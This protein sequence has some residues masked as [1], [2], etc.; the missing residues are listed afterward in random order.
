LGALGTAASRARRS[1]CPATPLGLAVARFVSEQETPRPL[2]TLGEILQ[3]LVDDALVLV[4]GVPLLIR[5]PRAQVLHRSQLYCQPSRSCKSGFRPPIVVMV[6]PDGR[7][8]IELSQ[9]RPPPLLDR[10][11]FS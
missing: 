3:L 7:L 2:L 4:S 9:L 6:N 11:G 1:T 5:V 8:W 10:Q